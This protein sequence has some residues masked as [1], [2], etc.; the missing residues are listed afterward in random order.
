MPAGL[1]AGRPAAGIPQPLPH[2][3]PRPPTHPTRA[4]QSY[5]L[6]KFTSPASAP[7]SPTSPINAAAAEWRYRFTAKGA[8][9]KIGVSFYTGQPAYFIAV[10]N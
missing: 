4:Q 6:Y 8:V 1:S 3:C 2:R 5:T 7:K 10:A 9:E